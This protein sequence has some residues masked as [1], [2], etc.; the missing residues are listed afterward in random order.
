MLGFVVAS[1]SLSI[2]LPFGALGQ[3]AEGQQPD[4][5]V[6]EELKAVYLRYQAEAH[7]PIPDRKAYRE[8]WSNEF[9]NVLT[10]EN[11]QTELGLRMLDE[12]GILQMNLGQDR[13]AS[14]TYERLAKAAKAA[15]DL[16]SRVVAA[17]H[18][19]NLSRADSNEAMLESAKTLK[20]A[21]L[22][23][24]DK[25][26]DPRSVERLAEVLMDIGTG[27]MSRSRNLMVSKN[28]SPEDQTMFESLMQ[29][30]ETAFKE[31]VALGE[32]GPAP[33][34][35]KLVW[36][37]QS[38]S[39][40]G[41]DEEAVEAFKK[42]EAMDQDVIS[43]LQ[44]TY[45]RIGKEFEI[46]SDAFHSAIEEALNAFETSG[47]ADE[48]ATVLRHELGLSFHRAG[49]HEKA[50]EHLN[51][52]LQNELDPNLVALE[53]FLLASSYGSIGEEEIRKDL[54]QRIVDEYPDSGYVE[55]AKEILD[56]PKSN[57]NSPY[58][59]WT[60]RIALG[61]FIFIPLV[62]YFKKS[63]V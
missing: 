24:V 35:S 57:P 5:N 47:K 55:D 3:G 10:A 61:L 33:L 2:L 31:A 58:K 44:V 7:N 56:A 20:E 23:Y 42:V 9:S 41:R 60:I 25:H 13:E 38:L 4:A 6:D 36:Y 11:E 52:N 28:Q 34:A 27:L 39:L 62:M 16:D 63:K 12:L 40:A 54:L 50:I 17:H 8:F 51:K 19:F 29:E 15:G 49:K 43:P 14:K 30:T 22:E 1:L 21:T 59:V 32:V 45:M 46:S 18:Q 37:G 26:D 48:Y 53:L